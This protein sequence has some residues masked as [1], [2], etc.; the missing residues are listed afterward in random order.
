MSSGGSRRSWN[1]ADAL[2]RKRKRAL[3]LLDALIDELFINLFGDPRSTA[4]RWL[5]VD[6]ANACSDRTASGGKIQRS[7]YLDRGAFPVVDQGQTFIAGWSACGDQLRRL[8]GPVIVFG[9]HTRAVKYVDFDFI[10][11]ADGAKVLLPSSRY[12]PRFFAELLR[13]MPIPD[14]GYSRHMRAL[15]ELKFPCPPLPMQT[16]C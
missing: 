16:G 1:K 3:E 4:D 6:F 2:R 5:T 9:D 15:K 14:L 11:G 7:E 12:E 10:V 13:R 8:S